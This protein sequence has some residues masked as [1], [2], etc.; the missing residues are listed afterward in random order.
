MGAII[1]R[2]IFN[3]KEVNWYSSFTFLSSWVVAILAPPLIGMAIRLREHKRSQYFLQENKL[4]GG[5]GGRSRSK[6]TD[7]Q[8]LASCGC[9]EN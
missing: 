7:V 9:G 6:L 1:D 2:D 4:V 3:C 5:G 8:W